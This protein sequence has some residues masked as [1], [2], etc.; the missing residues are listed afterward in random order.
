[1]IDFTDSL[2]EILESDIPNKIEGETNLPVKEMPSPYLNIKLQ[3]ENK[4]KK[5]MEKLLKFYLSQD[6][7][8]QDDYLQAKTKLETAN[9]ATMIYQ[10]Q[11]TERMI[12]KMM[13]EIDGGSVEPRMFEVFTALQKTLLDI[14]KSQTMYIMA[15][16][17]GVKKIS[18]ERDVYKSLDSP[19]TY[20]KPQ[21]GVGPVRGVKSLMKGIRDEIDAE[22]A[23]SQQ[24]N[25]EDIDNYL[26]THNDYDEEEDEDID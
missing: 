22:I 21:E 11:S 8:D 5:M 25:E 18:R 7:I 1:M 4:A 9:L 23:E 2:K 14:I 19:Q 26:D 12:D 6:F 15:T 3:A 20:T 16:E 10:M 24:Q 17:E 13:Y